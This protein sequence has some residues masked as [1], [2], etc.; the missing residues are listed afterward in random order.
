MRRLRELRTALL[1]WPDASAWRRCAAPVAAYAAAALVLGAAS[2]F[3]RPAPLPWGPRWLWLPW[4]MLLVPS[5]F[6]ELFFR[7]LFLPNRIASPEAARGWRR[8]GP[9]ALAVLGLAAY[10]LWHPLYAA[11]LRRLDPAS[12]IPVFDPAFLTLTALL[13]LC[14]SACYLRTGSIWAPTAV[15][16]ASVLVW[17]FLLGGRNP[18]L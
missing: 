2:E 4:S 15:H 16:W 12:P 7:G 14:C 8:P 18:A 10:V 13:G 5:L 6:E 3:L 9:L 17:V 1:S 11:V